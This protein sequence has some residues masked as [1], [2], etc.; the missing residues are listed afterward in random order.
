MCVHKMRICGYADGCE[1]SCIYTIVCVY[2]CKYIHLR[3]LS[4]HGCYIHT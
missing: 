1:R 3:R 2:V 4:V